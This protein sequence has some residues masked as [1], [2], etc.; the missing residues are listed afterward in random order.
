MV[1]DFNGCQFF[2]PI[3][4]PE[5]S[6]IIFSIVTSDFNGYEISCFGSNDG[7]INFTSTS[8]GVAPYQYSI[9]AGT[10]LDMLTLY[11][12][13]ISGTYDIR[14]VDSTGCIVESIVDLADPGD[15]EMPYAITNTVNCPGVCNG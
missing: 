10:N 14:V 6:E 1:E 7:E 4:M 13:L 15:F 8:G 9:D 3:Y 11:D 12:D 2:A 5:P